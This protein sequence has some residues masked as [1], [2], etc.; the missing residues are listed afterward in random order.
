MCVTH[1]FS[2]FNKDTCLVFFS[3]KDTCLAKT[4]TRHALKTQTHTHLDYSTHLH[5]VSYIKL[6]SH[7]HTLFR[8]SALALIYTKHLFFFLAHVRQLVN[9][10]KATL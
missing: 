2:S 8:I 9:I 5:F 4:H 10:C 6:N 1:N 3:N 7:T